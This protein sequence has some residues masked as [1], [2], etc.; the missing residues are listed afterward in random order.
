MI[1]RLCYIILVFILVPFLSFA[2]I[3]KRQFHS[4]F[5]EYNIGLPFT[6]QTRA[7]TI[8]V[9]QSKKQRE[10]D[11]KNKIKEITRA[12][13]QSKPEKITDENDENSKKRRQRR[14]EGME[15]P[16]EIIRRNGG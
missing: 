2:T 5:T 14:P 12:K 9:R 16:P 7:D 1:H 8:I 11:E 15:R 4:Y 13:K 6:V 3:K 10:E